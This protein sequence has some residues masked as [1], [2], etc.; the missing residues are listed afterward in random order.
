[1]IC[2]KNYSIPYLVLTSVF[3][4]MY[5]SINFSFTEAFATKLNYLG[6]GNNTIMPS[7]SFFQLDDSVQQMKI[8]VNETNTAVDI[9]N[10]TEAKHLLNKIYEELIQISNNANNLIWDI[11]NQGE[12]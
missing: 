3:I 11:S 2:I 5:F 6:I 10:N 4:F 1:M 7:D 8:L 9:N 12:T